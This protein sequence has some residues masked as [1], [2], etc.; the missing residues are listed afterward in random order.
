MKKTLPRVLLAAT[1]SGAGKT[2]LV[3]GLLQALKNRG[4]SPAAFKCGPDYIDPM[5]HSEVI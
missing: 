1:H 3:C 5:F 2:T 4:L